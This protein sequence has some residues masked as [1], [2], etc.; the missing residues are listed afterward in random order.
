MRFSFILPG[1]FVMGSVSGEEN[2]QPPHQVV[3]G[4]PFY[5]GT[6]VVTQRD[7]R[8]LMGTEPWKGDPHV[9]EGDRYPAVNVSW[10]DVQG[11]LGLMS[12]R[13]P[14]NS[15]SLPTEAEWEYA[16]RAGTDTQ[17]SFGDDERDLRF[18]GWYRDIT[19]GREEYVHE[20]GKKRPN[21]WGLYDMHGNVKEWTDDWYYGSYF[22]SAKAGSPG[23]GNTR[24]SVGLSCV[25]SAIRIPK[26]RTSKA[27]RQFHRLSRYTEACRAG[28]KIPG[29]AITS[30]SLVIPL[31]GTYL[32]LAELTLMPLTA[33]PSSGGSLAAWRRRQRFVD[34]IP[35]PAANVARPQRL[36][37]RG[38]GVSG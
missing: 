13:D 35:A 24:G 21:P 4:R 5:M 18:F 19:Q 14:G 26:P 31:S 16:A 17:F 23:E 38:V 12:E 2:E 32:S 20:V 33:R 37:S 1:A 10:Y 30:E 36:T 7:W 3:I 25:R 28:P 6:Y 34:L 29:N 27:I 22:R 15:Y 11:Y 9:R 8:E